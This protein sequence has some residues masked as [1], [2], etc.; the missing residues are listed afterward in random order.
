LISSS[1]IKCKTT[2]LIV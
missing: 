1:V 2:N